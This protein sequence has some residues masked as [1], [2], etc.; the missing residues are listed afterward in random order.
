MTTKEELKQELEKLVKEGGQL[1]KL[2]KKID[3]LIDFNRSYQSWF[4]LSVKIISTLARD[5]LLLQL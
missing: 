4:T 1:F 3:D 5:R 2:T